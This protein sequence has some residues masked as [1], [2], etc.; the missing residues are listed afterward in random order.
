MPT[1][2]TNSYSSLAEQYTY[3]G[4]GNIL[5]HRIIGQNSY[6]QDDTLTY[7]QYND[8]LTH[9]WP[10]GTTIT[11]SYD[12]NYNLTGENG[13]LGYTKTYTRDGLER[14]SAASDGTATVNIGYAGYLL[15]SSISFEGT[16]I[17]QTATYDNANRINNVTNANGVTTHYQY[18]PNDNITEV[19]ED[20]D[21]LKITTGYAFDPNDNLENIRDPNGNNTVLS[22]NNSDDLIQE[23]A[24]LIFRKWAYN[25]DGSTKQ[26]QDKNGLQQNYSYYPSGHPNAGQLQTN[27][28][29]T[30]EYDEYSKVVQNIRSPQA[31]GEHIQYSYD[32]VMRVKRITHSSSQTST[33]ATYQYDVSNNI[34]QI[35]FS[36]DGK[37]FSY[38]YDPLNR[39]I[40]VD[41]WNNTVLVQYA[42]FTS[43]LLKSETLGNG[44]IVNYHYDAAERLDSIWSMKT[45]GTILHAVGCSMDNNGNHIRE[46]TYINWNGTAYYPNYFNAHSYEYDNNNHLMSLGSQTV[47]SD[48]NGNILAN[49]Y[50]GFANAS[51]DLHNHLLACDVDGL[52]KVFT[53]DPLEYRYSNGNIAYTLDYLNN[54]NVLVSQ[55]K[56]SL[57]TQYFAH[58]PYGLVCSIEANTNKVTYYLYDFRGSTVALVDD[59]QNIAQYY[60]YNAF[61]EITKSS[62]LTKTTTPFLF[63]G[64]YGVMYESPHLYYMRARYYDPTIGRF[65]GEDAN[66]GTNLFTYGGNNPLSNIDPSGNFSVTDNVGF[67]ESIIPVWGSWRSAMYNAHQGNYLA[68]ALYTG[69]A[70]SDIFLV[71]SIITAGVK[72]IDETAFKTGSHEWKTTRAWLGRTGQAAK[73]QAVHHWALSQKTIEDFGLETIGNQP[74]NLMPMESQVFHQAIH[75]VGPNAFGVFGQIIHGT[76]VWFKSLLIYEA[77]VDINSFNQ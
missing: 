41:D 39:V 43:G 11:Y 61:G 19:I 34:T 45:D 16:N 64:K 71:K 54:G 25:D 12:A 13:P 73:G 3:D 67:G 56:T 24:G 42:Y 70:I 59:N 63:V 22:Y 35:Q 48:K 33:A 18:D 28:Y 30:F 47:T 52:H 65:L 76:P 77:K 23:T 10:N 14:I 51:Y 40:E 15:P 4:V 5:A 57:Y 55:D 9:K 49:A 60:Q 8:V 6:V 75:G 53:Y 27:G 69:L 1:L 66:W 50:T 20:V 68:A 31:P 72:I 62:E 44:V 2:I 46:S 58:S 21:T 37:H 32:D 29:Q 38:K 74:W 17:S 36:D 26:Y 7:D